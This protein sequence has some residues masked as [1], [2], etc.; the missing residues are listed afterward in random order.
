MFKS[1]AKVAG[2]VLKTNAGKGAALFGAG[3]IAG[4]ALDGGSSGSSGGSSGS[5]GSS[6]DNNKNNNGLFSGS[7]TIPI[8]IVICIILW[9]LFKR[10]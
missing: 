6:D 3:A 4:S 7:N 9:L 1:L 8:I 5:S 2:N 10:K